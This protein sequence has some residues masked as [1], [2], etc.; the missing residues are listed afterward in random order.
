MRMYMTDFQD[1]CIVRM[2]TLNLVRGDWRVYDQTHQTIQDCNPHPT[3][4]LTASSINIE[5]NNDKEPV[6]YILPPGISRVVDPSQPQLTENNEQ[7]LRMD[8]YDMKT[9]DGVAVYKN[10]HPLSLLP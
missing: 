9:N 3:G 4:R 6:N 8:I 5:E 1:S 7:S 10:T 2:A